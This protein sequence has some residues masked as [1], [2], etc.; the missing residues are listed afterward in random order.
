MSNRK[1]TSKR[2]YVSGLT[3]GSA[4]LEAAFTKLYAAAAPKPTNEDLRELF[5]ALAWTENIQDDLTKFLNR[6]PHLRPH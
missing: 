6:Y 3:L 1:V 5:A 4:D 2:P